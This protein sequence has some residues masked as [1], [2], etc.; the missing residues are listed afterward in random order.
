MVSSLYHQY[1]SLPSGLKDL[2]DCLAVEEL[3]ERTFSSEDAPSALIVYAGD[4]PT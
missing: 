2:Q 1:L 3:V 4:R